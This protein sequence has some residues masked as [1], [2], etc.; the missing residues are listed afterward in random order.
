M[1]GGLMLI[2]AS[3][4]APILTGGATVDGTYGSDAQ[5]PHAYPNGV[6]A[7]QASFADVLGLGKLLFDYNPRLTLANSPNPGVSH[8][9]F[10]QTGTAS[11][12]VRDGT[13][14][15]GLTQAVSYGQQDFSLLSQSLGTGGTGVQTQPV[16]TSPDRRPVQ[17][18]ISTLNSI[19]G[20]SLQELFS[21]RVTGTA[22]AIFSVGGGQGSVG[23]ATLP[24]QRSGTLSLSSAFV[25]SRLDS[26]SV[27]ATGIESLTGGNTGDQEARSV[28]GQLVWAH[29]F[30]P[31][32]RGSAGVGIA[33]LY[34]S[35][36]TQANVLTTATSIGNQGTLVAPTFL[37]S[38]AWNV[39]VRAQHVTFS[40]DGALQPA[41]DPFSGTTYMRGNA[42]FTA[43][44]TP[45]PEWTLTASALG[46]RIV[47]GALSGAFGAGGDAS[48]VHQLSPSSSAHLGFRAALVAPDHPLLANEGPPSLW[49]VLAG[50]TTTFPGAARK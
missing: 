31:D 16:Q 50:F 34:N 45:A 28:N 9:A 48:L 38:L 3:I 18:F 42:R 43:A 1:M 49:A 11:Y 24:L 25:T 20:A 44:W 47:G 36:P 19:T 13:E 30:D 29:A 39:P 40:L 7:G 17:R 12:L 32:L 2:V 46:D 41:L 5:T 21:P 4:G 6:M 33:V 8:V 23:R 35:T 22:R 26:L 37:A 10:F 27:S 14:V 15:Y